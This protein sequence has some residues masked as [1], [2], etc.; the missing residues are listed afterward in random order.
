MFPTRFCSGAP[1]ISVERLNRRLPRKRTLMSSGRS[2]NNS[3]K[4]SV[5]PFAVVH[6]HVEAAGALLVD[7]DVQVVHVRDRL[8]SR[9]ACD[10][11]AQVL[12]ALI[13]AVDQI[14]GW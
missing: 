3:R 9:V 4:V 8:G 2:G 12:G 1:G 6:F 5:E 11:R 10:E 14:P 13:A 7:V